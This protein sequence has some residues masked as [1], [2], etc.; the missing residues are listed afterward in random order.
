MNH[1]SLS[2]VANHTGITKSK[3]KYWAKLLNLKIKKENRTLFLAKGSESV[4]IAMA[5]SISC[6]LSPSTAA[7][8]VLSV[9]ALPVMKVNQN[10]NTNQLTNRISSLEEAVM[11]LVEQNKSLAITVENQNKVIVANLQSQGKQL[12]QLKLALNPPQPTKIEVWQPP[13]VKEPKLSAMQRIW[14][15]VMNPAKLRAN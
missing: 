9:H 3:I 5:Q 10:D 1:I 11:L 4:L 13:K 14:Y 6:G 8:E 15:E 2:E 12:N 7:K